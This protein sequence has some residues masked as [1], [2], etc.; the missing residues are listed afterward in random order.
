MDSC[1]DT[2]T[3]SDSNDVIF[4][5]CDVWCILSYSPKKCICNE[6]TH[7]GFLCSVSRSLSAVEL[8]FTLTKCLVI[9]SIYSLDDSCCNSIC[10][11]FLLKSFERYEV[12]ILYLLGSVVDNNNTNVLKLGSCWLNRKVVTWCRHNCVWMSIKHEVDSLCVLKYIYAAAA[13]CCRLCVNTKMCDTNNYVCAFSLEGIYL[14][15]WAVIQILALKEL[16]SSDIFRLSLCCSFRSF[17]SIETNLDAA[18]SDDGVWLEKRIAIAI[19]YTC[20]YCLELS[21][22]KVSL[23]LRYTIIKLVVTWSSNVI[24]CCIHARNSIKSLSCAYICCSLSEVTCVCKDNLCA[25]TSKVLSYGCDI[26]ITSYSTVDII[27]MK[28]YSL[29]AKIS[30]KVIDWLFLNRLSSSYCKA[31]H[32]KW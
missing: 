24:T 25:S 15:L 21:C 8:Y 29:T 12:V 5:N 23:K 26:R 18:L 19:K 31:G 16:I 20:A 22:C 13:L 14:S 4:I 11:N 10:D 27:G 9:L 32:T 30:R 2:T 7:V 17:K 1:T 3:V 6:V 28:D